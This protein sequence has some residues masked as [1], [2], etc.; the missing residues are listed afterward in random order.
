MSDTQSHYTSPTFAGTTTGQVL[1]S[2]GLDEY[3]AIRWARAKLFNTWINSAVTL[4][5]AYFIIKALIAIV[6]WGFLNAVWEVPGTNTQACRAVIG[7][8]ACW[9]LINEK[10]RFIMFGTYPYDEHWRPAIVIFIFLALYGVSAMRRFWNRNLIWIWVTGLT[11]IGILMWGGI[12][13]MRFVE[14]ERWGGL[15]ITLILATFGIALAFPLS[16]LLALGRRS[17]MP[18]VKVI[19]VTYIE[20]IRGVPLISLLFM[21]SVMFPLFL[22]EGLTIDKLLRAQVAIILFAAAYLA[23]VVRGG[24]QAIPK[25]Q[26]EAADSL[27]LT[28]WKKTGFIILPQALRL[29]IPPLVNT[30]I[31]LFKD[32]SLVL[33]IGIFDLLNSAKTAVN[34]PAWRGFGLEAYV[35]VAIIYFLFCF[36]MSKYSQDLEAELSRGHKR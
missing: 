15:P 4:V 21:A 24:L 26:Y 8:G 7:V 22:P 16:I 1:P 17:D 33:I 30:F 2:R 27:G 14:Q 25:G 18:A 34:E 20:L 35:F 32:T 23:E 12:L 28:F 9:A 29:V 36:A 6:S 31:G 3:A 13:G 5:F 11:A 10:F 19:C